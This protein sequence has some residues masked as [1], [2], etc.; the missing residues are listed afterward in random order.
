MAV[1]RLLIICCFCCLCGSAVLRRCS[2]AA[3]P[4]CCIAAF[5]RT[6][7]DGL[8]CCTVLLHR[9]CCI[10]CLCRIPNLS[11]VAATHTY[12]HTYIHTHTHARARAHLPTCRSLNR[13]AAEQQFEHDFQVAYS[14]EAHGTTLSNTIHIRPQKHMHAHGGA[15]FLDKFLLCVLR[16]KRLKTRPWQS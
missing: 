10:R 1:G 12:V 5:L 11:T 8:S 14:Q 4:P 7:R 6:A 3:E 9:C 2:V 13:Q 15:H 16:P